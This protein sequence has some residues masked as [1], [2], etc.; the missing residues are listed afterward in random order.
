MPV[1]DDSTA[2]DRSA[3]RHHFY[4]AVAFGIILVLG[5]FLACWLGSHGFPC[6]RGDDA[7][8]K[9]PA[10]ELAQNGSLAIPCAVGFL[11]QAE[12]VFAAYPPGFQWLLGAWYCLFG[13]SL[14][15]SLA[16]T[17]TVHLL[18]T[19]AVMEASRRVMRRDAAEKGGRS[20]LCGAPFGPFRQIGPVPFFQGVILLLIGA[21]QL[22]NLAYFDRP[23]ETALLFVWLEVLVAQPGRT[24][25]K[26][27]RSVAS[28]ALVGLAAL[29]SPWVGV[30]GVMVVV[31][32]AVLT[33]A[34]DRDQPRRR[35][36]WISAVGH[37]AVAISTAGGMAAVWFVLIE[38]LH[39]GAVGNQLFG[40]LGLLRDTQGSGTPAEKVAVFFYAIRYNLPQL[41]AVL[42]ALVLF[43]VLIA[44]AGWRSVGPTAL[45]LFLAG[46]L[47]IVTVAAIRPIAYTYLGASGMLLLPCLAAAIDYG[48]HGRSRLAKLGFVLLAFCAVI[49]QTDVVRLVRSS[50]EL[51]HRERPN[52]VFERLHA[53]IPPGDPVAVRSLHW[54]A[55]QG[56][57]PWREAYFS[58]IVD[59]GEVRRCRWLVLPP[60]VEPTYLDGFEL[61]E[62]VPTTAHRYRTYA[63]SLWRKN[64]SAFRVPGSGLQGKP[65]KRNPKP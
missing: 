65:R 6:P 46:V 32:R 26:I 42:L 4:P 62:R 21:I 39:P 8:Y 9:S 30:L 60:R 38:S 44:S 15:S 18:G 50:L 61:V 51:P 10:A 35:D 59:D 54:L 36:T 29:T 3:S 49:A 19:L 40:T 31:F 23:E 1:P 58:A 17:Y 55:F 12:R 20:D 52:V 14:Y 22:A 34:A 47:G 5:I 45:A 2:S 63:Y 24:P 57:N 48:I 27:R 37:L 56:R 41:P 33:A 64:G 43:P 11:P 53:V 28:G 16:F 25:W 7:M 13:V